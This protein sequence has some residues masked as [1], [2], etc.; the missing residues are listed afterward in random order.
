M[1]AP[2][3]APAS[4]RVAARGT[5]LRV[6]IRV[7]A[8]RNPVADE[9]AA[10][11]AVVR[12]ILDGLIHALK[13]DV[14][15][16]AG[17]VEN[18]K[19]KMLPRLYRPGDGDCGICFEYAVH[20]AM[21]RGDASV[22]ERVESAL[23]LCNIPGGDIGSILFGAEKTGSQQL[24]ETAHDALTGQSVLMYGQRGRP[25][26]LKRHIA[27]IA[28]AFRRPDARLNLPQSISGIWK[29]DLFIGKTDTD[30]WV[31]TSVKINPTSLAGAK[32]L[33]VGIVPVRQGE[34]DMP[35][36][37]DGRN[38]VVCPLLHDGNFMEVFYAGWGIVQQFIAAD[39]QLPKEVALPRPPEREVARQ[40]AHRR[41]FPVL[42]VIE[43]LGPLAQPELLVTDAREAQT[44]LTRGES[45]TAGAVIAPQARESG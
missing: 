24:I 34:S 28:Q 31:G 14:V 15:A 40:L 39:A 43:A 2:A 5:L 16:E 32:G 36:K 10:L 1:R 3:S 25:A 21:R 42:D 22:L 26:G 20:D 35:Y 41:E 6:D 30:K 23:G 27:A 12:P 11:F 9:V 18:V 29:A 13:H 19:L 8:Q 38:L 7:E 44:V 45:T 33:R 4:P 37:D 17:G